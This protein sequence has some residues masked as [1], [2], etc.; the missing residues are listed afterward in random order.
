[1]PAA[2]PRAALTIAL[3]VAAAAPAAADQE[4]ATACASTLSPSGAM[5]YR[6]A[7]PDMRRGSDLREVITEHTRD[8]VMSGDMTRSQ[9][10]PAAEAAAKCLDSLRS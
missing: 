7:A 10:R 4:A 8:L 5:I 2:I 3:L 1:M 9:A 6:N